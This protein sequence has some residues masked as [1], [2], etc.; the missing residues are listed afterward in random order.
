MSLNIITTM[1]TILEIDQKPW[2]ST[3]EIKIADLIKERQSQ[4]SANNIKLENE[5]DPELLEELEKF[6]KSKE[7]QVKPHFLFN[8]TDERSLIHDPDCNLKTYQLQLE[9]AKKVITDRAYKFSYLKTLKTTRREMLMRHLASMDRP[10]GDDKACLPDK[11]KLTAIVVVQLWSQPSKTEK[12]RLEREVLFRSDQNLTFLREH[13]RCQLDY[14]VPIDLGDNPDQAVRIFR[15]EMFKSGLFF[16]NQTFYNDLRSPNNNDLSSEIMGWAS[17]EVFVRGSDGRNQKVARGFGPLKAVKMEEHNFEDL[18]FRL[19]CP[20]LYL[21][22][23]DCE[24]LF[25]ISDVRYTTGVQRIKFPLV[26]ASALGGKAHCL[27][28]YMCQN[29]P[30]HW[31]TRDNNRL[32]VDPFF[33]CE[34]CFYSFNYDA[35][36]KKIGRFRAYLYTSSH[37]IPTGINIETD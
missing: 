11:E 7:D 21:H 24:H 6:A 17:R 31:Y 15:G 16:V 20:Y 28:C 27:R 23:G 34:N 29:R 13:F 5:G 22:Q 18:E 36:K 9:H 10:L 37:G 8:S 2:I 25:T 32:P 35:N 33:F 4:L 1:D 14:E 30:P 12:V 3:R 19:G 26:T